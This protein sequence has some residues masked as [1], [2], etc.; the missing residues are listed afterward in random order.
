MLLRPG[1]RKGHNRD[2][3]AVLLGQTCTAARQI[4]SCALLLWIAAAAQPLFAIP[5]KTV[6]TIEQA[7]TS[8]GDFGGSVTPPTQAVTSGASLTYTISLFP[9]NGF[10]SDV[11]ISISGLPAGATATFSPATVPGGSGTSILTI[12]TTP[13]TPAG[14]YAPILTSNGGG[15][16]H[17]LAIYMSVDQAAQDFSLAETPTGQTIAPGATATYNVNVMPQNGFPSSVYLAVSGL[18]PGAAATFAPAIVVGGSGASVLTIT[19]T[20]ATPAGNYSLTLNGTSGPLQH[21]ATIRLG[22]NT[23]V[24]DFTGSVSPNPETVTQGS[25]AVYAVNVVPLFGFTSDVAL[26]V[27]GLPPGASASFNPPTVNAGSGT[28]YLSVVTSGSTPPGTYDIGVTG[29]GG[30]ITHSGGAGLIVTPLPVPVIQS[31]TIFSVPTNAGCSQLQVIITGQNF[32]FSSTVQANGVSLAPY[33]VEYPSTI[34]AFLPSNFVSQSGALSFTVSNP[35]P[36]VATSAPFPYSATNP[37]L[38]ALCISPSPVTVFPNSNFSV[39]VQASE[40]NANANVMVALGALPS[41]IT[42]PV[43]SF[44]VPMSGTTLHFQAAN[45]TTPGNYDLAFNATAGAATT[46]ADFVFTVSSGPVP[47]FFFVSPTRTEVGVPIG[48][49]GSIQYQTAVDSSSPLDF[50]ITPSATGLPPG[51]T[52]SFSPN[53]F[54]VGQAVT[55]TLTAANNAPVTQNAS[56]T[57]TGTASAQVASVTA[58]FLADVTQPPGSL[59]GNRTDFVSTG[60][61]PYRAVYDATHNLIFSSNPDWNRVDV[62]SNVTHKII[63]SVPVRWPR[64]ID[65]TPDNTQVWVQAASQNILSINTSSL[66]AT[67][68]SLPSQAPA[69]S[70]LPVSFSNDALLAL[71]DGTLFVFIEDAG[72]GG[73]GQAAIFNPQ[74]NQLNLLT[75]P[76]TITGLSSPMRSGDG[77]IVYVPNGD[78]L[79]VYSVSQQTFTTFGSGNYSLN[80]VNYDGSQIVVN[81]LAGTRLYNFNLGYAIG[82][83]PGVPIGGFNSLNGGGIIFSTDSGKL[84]EVAG[85]LVLTIDASTLNVLGTAPALAYAGTESPFAIDPTG[86]LLSTETFGITFDD[87][88]FYQHYAANQPSVG[89]AAIISPEAGPLTG[90]TV[91]TLDSFPNLTPDVWFGQTRGSVNLSQ[92]QLTFTSPPSNTPGPVNVKFIFPDGDQAF[93][94]QLFSYSTFPE[95]AVLSGSSPSG[96][97]PATVLGYGLPLDSAGGTVTVGSAVAQIT[98][99]AGQY[100]PFSGEPFPSTILSYTFPAGAPGLAD[101]QIATP[102]GTGTLPKAI[103]YAESV[104]DYPSSDS[105]TAVLVDAKR[106]QVYLSAGDHIDVFSTTSSQFLAPLQPAALGSQKQ[107]VGLALTPDGS[108]L[109]AADVLDASLAVINPDTPSSTYAIAFPPQLPTN[110]CPVGPLYVAATSTNLAFVSYGS[111]PAPACPSSGTLYTADLQTHA[112]NQTGPCGNALGIDATSDGNFVVIGDGPCIYNAQ[113]NSYVQA[114]FSGPGYYDL[115]P[116]VS[117]DGSILASGLAFANLNA[118]LLGGVAQPI[119]LYGLPNS[120]NQPTPLLGPKLNHSGSLYYLSYP[121]YFEIIDVAHGILRTRF[122]LTETIQ[123]TASPLAIDS[124]GRKVYLLTDEGLTVVD[125]GAAPLSISHDSARAASPGTEVVVHGSGFDSTTSAT[126][127]GIA[128]AASTTDENTLTLTTPALPSGPHDIVLRR[129]DGATYTFE[130]AVVLP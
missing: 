56:V 102:I 85:N 87:A 113:T 96:G 49:S 15:I 4:S 75:T 90:G 86:I 27:S 82:P 64:D 48:G 21:T 122:S 43:Q 93:Y 40:V 124:G 128:A 61:T 7:P 79:K 94:P 125:L 129:S 106:K 70:G 60:G 19:T 112:V 2:K 126:V 14:A 73:E 62:I 30:G 42:A 123:D 25:T 103:L 89:F 68:Y 45:T 44:Q 38:L 20:A 120:L 74:T 52:A 95:Y 88:T 101:L 110:A 57:L 9:L 66:Q 109:L 3:S 29:V 16:T 83:I 37:A 36:L 50:D 116:A 115:N 10:A 24:V 108:Q 22:V 111:L 12:T 99:V 1:D 77:N 18:P 31:V 78:G 55:V 91:S 100:P 114:Q 35:G 63:K 72:V 58:S 5:S 76:G 71:S 119:A 28:S 11:T 41:G 6:G 121:N 26:T 13:A 39:T 92:G 54:S 59:P 32:A 127:G 107:F 104:T 65:I 80:A 34:S 69:S 98:T 17:R 84:Y 46:T 33:Y 51:T 23:P 47:A 117:G 53:V 105:F 130:N 67:Q 97:A 118:N 81:S 8:V